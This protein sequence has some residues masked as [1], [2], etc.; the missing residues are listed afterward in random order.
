MAMNMTDPLEKLSKLYLQGIVRL[1]GVPKSIVSDRDPRFTSGYWKGLQRALGTQ[2]RLS[3][4]NHPQTDGQSERI[5]QIRQRLLAAQNRQKRY[6]D[7]RMKPLTFAVGDRVF[8]KVSSRKGLQSARKLGKLAPRFVGPFEITERIGEVA[9]R[10][11]L[12]PQFSA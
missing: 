10:L 5:I 8:I 2:L 6:A 3:T 1:H 4:S 12:P 9:Y 11:S 7:K